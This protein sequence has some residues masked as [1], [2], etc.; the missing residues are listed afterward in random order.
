VVGKRTLFEEAK[1]LTLSPREV[2]GILDKVMAL[3]EVQ[4]RRK[5]Q[6]KRMIFT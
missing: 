3:P 1:V 6:I 5:Q 4:Q 2:L